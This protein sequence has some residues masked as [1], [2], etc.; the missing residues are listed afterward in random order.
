MN[1]SSL[2]FASF[3]QHQTIQKKI[4]ERISSYEQVLNDGKEKVIMNSQWKISSILFILFVR[5]KF[6]CFF[7][8]SK[9]YLLALTIGFVH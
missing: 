3:Q 6:F 1:V 8:Y 2:M 4:H 5:M 7:A 9:G